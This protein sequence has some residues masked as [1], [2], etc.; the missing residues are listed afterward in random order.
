MEKSNNC[1]HALEIVGKVLIFTPLIVSVPLIIYA[2]LTG[3]NVSTGDTGGGYSA[4]LMF[5]A[6]FFILMYVSVKKH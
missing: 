2:I 1:L 6:G 4:G 5:F 3:T